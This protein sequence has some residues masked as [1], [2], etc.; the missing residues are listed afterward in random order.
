MYT[1]KQAVTQNLLDAG[2]DCETIAR[3]LRYEKEGDRE[4]QM[5]LLAAHRL[6]LLEQVH[7]EEK[8]IACLDYLVYQLEKTDDA[9]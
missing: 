3:F 6:R 5:S 9:L 1:S 8:R 7:Q 2:C 4:G